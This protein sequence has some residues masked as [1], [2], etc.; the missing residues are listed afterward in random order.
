MKGLV[1]IFLFS[2]ISLVGFAQLSN[3]G[4]TLFVQENAFVSSSMNIN[5]AGQI[6]NRGSIYLSADWQNSNFYDTTGTLILN[7][8]NTQTINHNNQKFNI[9]I[10]DG[11]G[12]KQLNSNASILT[13]LSLKSGL[14][15]VLNDNILILGENAISSNSSPSSYVNGILY[16]TGTGYKFYPIG[17]DDIYS[18]V[19]LVNV[20]KNST[21]GIGM[22]YPN[23]NTTA[24]AGLTVSDSRYYQMSSIGTNLANSKISLAYDGKFSISDFNNLV[25]VQAN[26]TEAFQSI[27]NDLAGALNLRGVTSN[28]PLTKELCTLAYLGKIS[29][30]LF[31][32]SAL[33]PSAPNLEDRVVKIY[34]DE[35]LEIDFLFMVFNKWGNM[36]FS[37][38]SLEF[39]KN[40]GWDGTNQKTGKREQGGM[41]SYV[42]KARLLDE[43]KTEKTGTIMIIN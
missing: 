38:N 18:P 21:I 41:Y 29:L 24:D 34:G 5:N 39:M 22:Y 10:I 13:E 3:N 37:S 42:V 20:E 23:L 4:A 31:I 26:G 27:G 35:F 2:I 25:I 30:A 19:G 6:F 14:L 33:S 16:Q 1:F 8:Q 12:E 40:T 32:P 28:L 7:G 17:K 11:P 15:T 9:L 36:V 43:S